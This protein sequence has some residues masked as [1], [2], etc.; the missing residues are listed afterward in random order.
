MPWYKEEENKHPHVFFEDDDHFWKWRQRER[1]EFPA[2]FWDK[3]PVGK[4]IP[5][6][7]IVMDRFPQVP[8]LQRLVGFA[9]DVVIYDD[10]VVAAQ[11]I[12]DAVD[13][14]DLSIDEKLEVLVD[15]EGAPIEFKLA[16]ERIRQL[17]ND[18]DAL[19]V[20]NAYDNGFDEG[21]ELGLE[22]GR[23]GA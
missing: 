16:L 2:E 5:P 13:Y 3:F 22:A 11:D 1:P 17:E 9:A 18:A 19:N 23:D 10:H 7:G 6:G 21:Y 20:Q 8:G 15:M 4:I 12:E 14:N